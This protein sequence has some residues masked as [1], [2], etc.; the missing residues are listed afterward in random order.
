M[1][2]S[3]RSP[4]R[5][6]HRAALVAGRLLVLVSLIL[7]LVIGYEYVWTDIQA[8]RAAQAAL[9]RRLEQVARARAGLP[10]VADA[11]GQSLVPLADERT[12]DLILGAVGAADGHDAQALILPLVFIAGLGVAPALGVLGAIIGVKIKTADASEAYGWVGTGQLVGYSAGAAIAGIA[13][14]TVSPVAALAISVVLGI[15]AVIVALLTLGITP[16]L[17]EPNPDT[18]SITVIKE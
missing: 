4:A 11:A 5:G 8:K 2:L 14:D 9:T 12:Y 13:I 16:D 17:G 1:S 6:R 18:Q 15:G 7:A 10:A 3:T